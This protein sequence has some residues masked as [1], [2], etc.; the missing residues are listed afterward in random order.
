MLNTK[1]LFT[2]VLT[3]LKTHATNI[4]TLQ[5][6]ANK[7]KTLLWSG[8]WSSSTISVPNWSDYY[9][10]L[11]VLDGTPVLCSR[12]GTLIR[13]ACIAGNTTSGN[14]TEYVRTFGA[15]AT[16]GTNTWTLKWSNGLTHSTSSTY[17]TSGT[18]YTVTYIYGII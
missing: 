17:H 11:V 13:G 12:N 9:V 15:N 5:T 7:Q 6:K 10:Y 18:D 3:E 16:E 1:K 8:S 2:K 4:S 14:Y